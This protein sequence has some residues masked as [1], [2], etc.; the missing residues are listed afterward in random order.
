MVIYAVRRTMEHWEGAADYR[1]DS[2]VEQDLQEAE[3]FM[4]REAPVYWGRIF[5]LL[6]SALI[7]AAFNKNN[8]QIERAQKMLIEL[9]EQQSVWFSTQKLAYQYAERNGD[10]NSMRSIQAMSESVFSAEF[11]FADFR[12]DLIKRKDWK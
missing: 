7:K 12:Y 11:Q 6:R 4:S 5:Y 9:R 2:G 1:K 10:K 3:T 8:E